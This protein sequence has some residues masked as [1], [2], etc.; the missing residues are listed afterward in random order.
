MIVQSV[1]TN[2]NQNYKTKNDPSFSKNPTELINTWN[3]GIKHKFITKELRKFSKVLDY[4]EEMDATKFKRN[5]GPYGSKELRTVKYYFMDSQ[6]NIEIPD[7]L[8]NNSNFK[9]Y[10]NFLKEKTEHDESIT[11]G[12]YLV[13]LLNKIDGST[14]KAKEENSFVI[15]KY[16]VEKIIEKVKN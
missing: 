11:N 2:T 9:K 7:E 10:D 5:V 15:F 4:F 6:K 14:T 12:E 8:K 13:N 1:K 3:W 16:A